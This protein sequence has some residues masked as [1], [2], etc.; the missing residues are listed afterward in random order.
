MGYIPLGNLFNLLIWFAAI[1]M[2]TV[3][4]AIVGLL[5][6]MYTHVSVTLI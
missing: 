1:G 2:T 3:C 6:F 4:V 5:Y